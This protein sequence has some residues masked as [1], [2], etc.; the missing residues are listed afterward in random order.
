MALPNMLQGPAKDW[1]RA[2]ARNLVRVHG[3]DWAKWKIAMFERFHDED[4]RNEA[5]IEYLTL[6]FKSFKSI[7][8]Y[9]AKKYTLRSKAYG[10]D[11]P[12][13]QSETKL[14]AQTLQLFPN[15]ARSTIKSAWMEKCLA[16]GWDYRS[17]PMSW[18]Q[19][20]RLVENLLS[21]SM[22]IQQH[23]PCAQNNRHEVTF[24]PEH[25]TA[26]PKQSEGFNA[27][28][29]YCGGN[30]HATPNCIA[31]KENKLHCAVCKKTNHSTEMHRSTADIRP[32]RSSQRT[33]LAHG[34]SDSEDEQDESSCT[35]QV[36]D[37]EDEDEQ[38]F[39]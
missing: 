2:E 28:C 9:M 35:G 19:F 3:H 34:I 39:L 38:N 37:E 31:A 36:Y 14:I 18:Q 23:D 21:T 7:T 13:D 20:T 32:L 6:N 26:K 30:D 16:G 15:P 11:I 1:L 24:A 29:R 22:S 12:E 17:T 27:R 25:A 5:I 33:Y 10:N 4:K 8:K